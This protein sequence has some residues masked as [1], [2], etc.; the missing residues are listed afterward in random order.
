MVLPQIAHDGG[1]KNGRPFARGTGKVSPR[2]R[3]G[4]IIIISSVGR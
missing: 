4:T 2:R 3:A 1:A